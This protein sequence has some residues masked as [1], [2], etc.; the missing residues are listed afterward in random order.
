[1][2]SVPSRAKSIGAI[3]VVMLMAMSSDVPASAEEGFPACETAL[4]LTTALY[5]PTLPPFKE[6]LGATDSYSFEHEA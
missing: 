1:M 4:S 6:S 3:V 2:K 5:P